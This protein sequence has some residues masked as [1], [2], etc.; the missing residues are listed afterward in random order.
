MTTKTDLKPQGNKSPYDACTLT[1]EL[2]F[3]DIVAQN[4]P[5]RVLEWF[6]Y[7][8]K[9]EQADEVAEWMREWLEE[10]EEARR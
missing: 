1:I 5:L 6:I 3:E 9:P 2:V 10:Y 7:A 8:I 4:G